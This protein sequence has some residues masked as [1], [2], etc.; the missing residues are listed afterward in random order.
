MFCVGQE[1][2]IC[3]EDHVLFFLDLIQFLSIVLGTLEIPITPAPMEFK[4]SDQKEAKNEPTS[5]LLLQGS[6]C[7]SSILSFVTGKLMQSL[8]SL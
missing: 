5:F 4:P 2:R 7:P 8:F 3:S 6:N 1:R